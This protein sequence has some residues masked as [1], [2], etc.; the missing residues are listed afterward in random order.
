MLAASKTSTLAQVTPSRASRICV[1]SRVNAVTRWPRSN[2]SLTTR[3][4]MV[5]VAP[6]TPICIVLLRVLLQPP[7][8]G[9]FKLYG[10][11]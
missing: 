8:G 2:A 6:M 11:N 3:L 4:P 7:L 9:V 10:V 1:S 5:P